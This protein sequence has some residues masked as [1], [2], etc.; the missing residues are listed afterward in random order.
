MEEYVDQ[1]L[2]LMEKLEQ[3]LAG[4][5]TKQCFSGEMMVLIQLAK[6][7][8]SNPSEL[9]KQTGMSSPHIAKTICSL[10]MKD[11]VKRMVDE[12]DRRKAVIT[13]TEKGKQRIEELYQ[14][15]KSEITNVFERIGE[16]DAKTFT[17]IFARI[18][19]VD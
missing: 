15:L 6:G 7:N 13:I 2:F 11:E 8:I 1:M 19:G 3:S 14:S 9:T 17:T 10:K 18:M 12:N 5:M 4:K 16:E